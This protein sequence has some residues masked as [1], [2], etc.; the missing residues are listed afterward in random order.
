MGS[1][2]GRRTAGGWQ[3]LTVLARSVW[4]R[5]LGTG[6]LLED[7]MARAGLEGQAA[8]LEQAKRIAAGL[9]DA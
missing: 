3:H 6:L 7:G 8:R 4:P 5:W 2:I 1:V 9:V